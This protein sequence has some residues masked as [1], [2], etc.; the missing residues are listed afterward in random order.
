[1][2]MD[3]EK[4]GRPLLADN[5]SPADSARVDGENF[6][7]SL[8]RYPSPA[9]S[10]AAEL[11]HGP[12]AYFSP[13]L[14]GLIPRD[15]VKTPSREAVS[16]YKVQ[17]ETTHELSSY[18][19]YKDDQ[20]LRNPGGNGYDLEKKE[21]I[22]GE[23]RSFLGRIG[24]DLSNVFGNVKN[25]LANMVSGAKFCYRDENNHIKEANRKGV[26]GSIVAFFKDLG[27]AFTF[28]AWRPDGESEPKG[29]GKRLSY[30]FS[31]LYKAF[32]TDLL[33]DVPAAVNHMANDLALA[34]WNLL[35]VVPDATLGN[36]HAGEKATSKIFDNGQV[37]IDYVADVLPSGE[38]WKRVHA[39]DF[40][41][42]KPPILA[43]LD[44]AE[45]SAEDARWEYVRNTPFR[46]T[47]ET[48]GAL[49]A[50]V[51]TFGFVRWI[52]GSSG[53]DKS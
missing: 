22:R 21:V 46:K 23:H 43:N 51:A 42:W 35:K 26:L 36:L 33:G 15:Q 29:L 48:V 2:M 27:S 25:F 19:K 7:S 28:G 30:T 40:K 16:A 14:M 52:T 8:A 50:D 53:K 1:M 17:S 32:S 4:I 3:I 41:N 11:Q 6:A 31:K 47:I 9:A 18:Q 37:V 12:T 20:L 38:A 34:G 24:R 45:R 49:L 39:F 13:A 5:L 10:G 44:K